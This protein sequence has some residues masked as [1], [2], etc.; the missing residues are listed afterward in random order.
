[1]DMDSNYRKSGSPDFP[2][3]RDEE[4]GQK[5]LNFLRRRLDLPDSL[6]HR[7]IRGGQ[8]RV[9]GLRCKAF[10]RLRGGDIVR[11][12]PFATSLSNGEKIRLAGKR[13]AGEQGGLVFLEC[14]GMA[15]DILAINKP[16]GMPVHAGSGHDEGV[17]ERLKSCFA[18]AAFIPTPA[19][20]LDRDTS[21]LLLIGASYNSLRALQENL[22]SGII[23]KEYVAWVEGLWPHADPLPLLDF[24]RRV[25][26][27]PP[28]RICEADDA[29]AREALCLVAPLS[30]QKDSSLLH[31]LLLSG[32]KHQI[33][34]QLAA[35]G[36]PVIGDSRYG[37]A[38][39]NSALL[40]HSLRGG[41]PGQFEF[42]C[43]PPWKG[44]YAV[45]KLV[46]AMNG[47]TL[48]NTPHLPPHSRDENPTQKQEYEN[49]RS[50]K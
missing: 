30:R 6:L 33:R 23:R 42:Y 20:R 27:L 11:V 7:W 5:L 48:E 44:Q 25:D 38:Q 19:H 36:H 16:A 8:T 13:Q 3:V 22:H 49:E 4:S 21:G 35:R 50:D 46:P 32:R 34:A 26:G 47:A 10:L 28:M 37:H 18:G 39:K 17:A 31:I 24:I 15:K 2:P 41:I 40:L 1:M 43:Q 9:N 14:R 29:G 45:Q 12:P